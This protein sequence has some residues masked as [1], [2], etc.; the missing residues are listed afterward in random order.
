M[1][2]HH[3][4]TNIPLLNS[5]VVHFKVSYGFIYHE[6]KLGIFIYFIFVLQFIIYSK[7]ER[8]ITTITIITLIRM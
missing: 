1:D 2:E 3:F 6:S 7:K 8:T 4:H 5:V